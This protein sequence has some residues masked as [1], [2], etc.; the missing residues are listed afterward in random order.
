MAVFTL[1]PD[2]LVVYKPHLDYIADHAVDADK[3]RYAVE[4]EGAR[5]YID[6][7]HWP[8]QPPLDQ[9]TAEAI[10]AQ[11]FAVTASQDTVKVNV[12]GPGVDT[13]A[14]VSQFT[15]SRPRNA[16][17][18]SWDIPMD[19]FTRFLGQSQL[20]DSLREA[21]LV[22][23]ESFTRHGVLPYHLE[24]MQRRLTSAFIERDLEKILK[25]SADIGHYIGDAHVPLHTT[26]N[27]NGQL[28]GQTGIHAFW[29]SR[30][31]EL[32][33]EEEFDLLAGRADYID[34]P[35]EYFWSIVLAS[36]DL[37]DEVLTIEF[38]LRNSYPKSKQ[39][40][41]VERGT[42]ATRSECPRYVRRYNQLLEGM[43]EHRMKDAIQAIGSSWFTAWVDA[44]QPTPEQ[45]GVSVP[46]GPVVMQSDTTQLKDSIEGVL[47]RAHPE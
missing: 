33:A 11:Y 43:V 10:F 18:E 19:S 32:L 38:Q 6:L 2:L 13:T 31:P 9:P 21:R 42:S 8:E 17:S 28:T 30:I 7:D 26:S 45:L 40:C 3:R 29:E 36:H 15:R 25:L 46:G 39:F 1:P 16:N 44:G 22:V 34:N 47:S 41:F 35:R 5:H 24:R 37:V 27:Y 20:P 23:V 12:F 14:I 4:F